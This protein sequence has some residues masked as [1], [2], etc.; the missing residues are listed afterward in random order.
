M[1]IADEVERRHH[2]KHC[3]INAEVP[4]VRLSAAEN[5]IAT[6]RARGAI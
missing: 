2:R 1:R 6:P 5:K 3:V 4:R